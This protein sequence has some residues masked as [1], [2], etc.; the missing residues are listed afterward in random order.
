RMQMP[1]ADLLLRPGLCL[2]LACSVSAAPAAP[3]P[4]S[5]PGVSGR[6]FHLVITGGTPG[7]IAMAVRAAREGLDVLLVNRTQHLGGML[8]SGLGVWDTLYE[9]HR[10]PVYDEVRSAIFSHYRETYGENSPQYRASLP[11]PGGHANG[12]FEPSVAEKILT[13]LVAREKRIVVLNGFVIG[14]VEVDGRQV[15]SATFREWQGRRSVRVSGAVF[16]DCTYEGDLLAAAGAPFRVGREARAEFDEPHAGRVFLRQLVQPP[17]PERARL[18]AAHARLNLRRFEGFQEIIPGPST[19]EGDGYVQAYNYRTIL[20]TDPANRLP[21]TKP[22]DYHP[23]LLRGLEFD[24]V[25]QPLPN[26]KGSWNRPQLAGR[27]MAYVEGGWPT[28]KRVMDE[29]WKTVLALLYFVQNDPSVPVERREHWRQ[30]GLARDEFAGNGNRPYEI[31]VR[32]ARRLV[33]RYVVTQ[34][35]VMTARHYPRAPIHGDSVAITEWY[36]DSLPILPRK[37]ED[38]Y[39]DGKMQLYDE[40][41]PG[42]IPYRAL[43]APHVDNLLV[44]V[45][46]SSTHIAWL[47]IRLEA[48]WMHVAESSAIAAALAVR[49]HQSPAALDSERLLRTLAAKRVMLTF[50]NDVDVAGGEPWVPAAEYFGAKGFFPDYDARPAAPLTPQVA[51]HWAAGFA[52]LAYGKLAPRGLAATLA[53]LPGPDSGTLSPQEFDRM[54][55]GR[56]RTPAKADL[57][58]LT[59]GQ[60]LV[61]MWERIQRN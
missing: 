14:S 52:Q 6:R 35:D 54:L 17:N 50:F 25:I 58:P 26:S 32:E 3:A 23:E 40:S 56:R 38:S 46:V 36:L 12:R 9:G 48:T 55:P 20:T 45:C 10:S 21:V 44:P 24:S 31:Y 5:I 19:G 28:R 47:A 16:A 43:L 18:A 11:A 1:L 53:G 4:A 39:A 60:A 41:F 15:R 42:Q 29:H 61:L 59:R 2:L 27:H 34:Q 51:R 30:Y 8:S 37:V 7:G 57:L 49:S 33:G 13:R 22:D